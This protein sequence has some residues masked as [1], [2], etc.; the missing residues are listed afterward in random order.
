VTNKELIEV[1]SDFPETHGWRY[2]SVIFT[3]TEEAQV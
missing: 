3:A 2:Q 1:L